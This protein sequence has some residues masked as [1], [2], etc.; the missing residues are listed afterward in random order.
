MDHPNILKI[1]EFYQD[2]TNFYIVSEY[3]DGG[4]LFD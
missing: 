2:D 3:C 1:Y 4:E